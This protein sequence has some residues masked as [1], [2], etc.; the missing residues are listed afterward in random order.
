MLS[1]HPQLSH[2]SVFISSSGNMRHIQP[3]E[4]PAFPAQNE[5]TPKEKKW[6]N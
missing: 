6:L 1:V 3:K 4:K 2:S 5:L